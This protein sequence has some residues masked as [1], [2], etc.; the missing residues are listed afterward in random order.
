M[1]VTLKHREKSPLGVSEPMN[2]RSVPDFLYTYDQY[3]RIF[4]SSCKRTAFHISF[5][6]MNMKQGKIREVTKHN[7]PAYKNQYIGK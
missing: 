7:L 5:M 3:S 2:G 4:F 1:F 6:R